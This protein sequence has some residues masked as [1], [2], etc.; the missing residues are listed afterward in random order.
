[1]TNTSNFAD[2]NRSIRQIIYEK[3]TFGAPPTHFRLVNDERWHP[4]QFIN[5]TALAQVQFADGSVHQIQVLWQV[6]P[7][8]KSEEMPLSTVKDNTLFI[9]EL[10]QIHATFNV[11]PE[12]LDYYRELRLAGKGPH[13]AYELACNAF[14][15]LPESSSGSMPSIKVND[16]DFPATPAESEVDVTAID[17]MADDLSEITQAVAVKENAMRESF[18][19]EYVMNG[20]PDAGEETYVAARMRGESIADASK[21]AA[22]SMEP[23][24]EPTDLGVNLSELFK[25]S[26][27]A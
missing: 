5:N 20:W 14:D 9:R 21:L 15:E 7:G 16:P 17:N 11:G 6:T 18:R 13:L 10:E 24:P 4:V 3:A 12:F 1:M 22:H 19:A 25:P 27:Q 23:E 26:E 2:D 8:P